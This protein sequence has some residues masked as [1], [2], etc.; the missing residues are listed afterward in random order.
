MSKY[1]SYVTPFKDTVVIDYTELFG[2]VGAA[3][4]AGVI[5]EVPN[6]NTQDFIDFIKGHRDK[7]Y[8]DGHLYVNGVRYNPESSQIDGSGVFMRCLSEPYLFSVRVATDGDTY[9]TGKITIRCATGTHTSDDTVELYV[10]DS[11]VQEIGDRS[12]DA[13][14]IRGR[15]NTFMLMRTNPKLTGNIKLVVDSGGHL[16]LDTFKVS[17][18]LN[19]RVYRKYPV[20][21]DGNYPRDVMTVFGSLPKSELFKTAADTLN[22]H[23]YYTD[24]KQQYIT[25]YEYGAET[26]TDNMYPENM[27]ILAPIHI[28]KNVP[29][30]FCVF[31]YDGTYNPDTYHSSDIDDRKLF[32]N[33][34][35]TATVIKIFDLRS[36]TAVG[37]YIHNYAAMLNQ[38]LHGSCFL[39]FIEQDNDRDSKNYRQGN[40]SWRGIDVAHGLITNKIESSYFA[41]NI[42][43]SGDAVQEK[44]NDY[45]IDG[46]ERNN[47]LYPYILNLEF[48]FNDTDSEEFSMNRYYGLYL[49]ANEYQKYSCIIS[50]TLSET[51]RMLKLDGNDEPVSD[52]ALIRRTVGSADYA[53]RIFFMTTNNDAA[54]VQSA[55]DVKTFIDDYVLDNPDV[56]IANITSVPIEWKAGDRSFITLTFR[57]PVYYGE[58]LRFVC[59]NWQSAAGDTPE[60]ICLEI[61]A[62]NDERLLSEDDYIS[63]YVLT[64]SPDLHYKT[65]DGMTGTSF[66]RISFY[67]QSTTDASVPA[68]VP[69]QMA[70][71]RAA[72]AR[73]G[74]FVK[75]TS[76][77]DDTLCVVSS[78]DDTYF[79]H[80]MPVNRYDDPAFYQ[81]YVTAADSGYAL[82]YTGPKSD[83]VTYG[84]YITGIR[85]ILGQTLIPQDMPD[86]TS[87]A[88]DG[89]FY[90][91]QGVTRAADYVEY[92]D[93]ANIITD[94]IRYFS[95][96][97][98]SDMHVL[99]P[100]TDTYSSMYMPLSM[101]G[102]ENLGWRYSSVIPFKKMTDYTWPYAVYDDMEA[103]LKFTKHPLAKGVNGRF[104]TIRR[105]KTETGY[106]TDNAI[107][108]LDVDVQTQQLVT[109]GSEMNT[110]ISPYD[111]RSVIIDF[112][113]EPFCHNS[114]IAL[115]NPEEA[116]LCVMGIMSVKDIDMRIN[117]DE[118]I[119]SSNRKTVVIPAGDIVCVGSPDENR[120][121]KDAVYRITAGS[122]QEYPMREFVMSGREIRYT[123][124]GVNVMTDAFNTGILTAASDVT[125]E[126]VEGADAILDTDVATTV[127][128]QTDDNFFKDRSSQATSYLNIPVVPQTN[129]LWESNGLYFDSNPILD[130]SVLTAGS[131]KPEGHFTEL[132]V[133]PALDEDGN[134]FLKNS[135]DSFMYGTQTG[136]ARFRDA[137]KTAS[138]R[139]ILKKMIVQ[140]GMPDTAVGYY[141]SYVQTLEFVYYGIKFGLKFNSDYYNQNIHIGEYNNFDVYFINEPSFSS[142]NEMYISVDEQIIVFVNHKFDMVTDTGKHYYPQMTAVD[143]GIVPV[144]AYSA[145]RAPYS[146]EADS[147][148]G[149]RSGS[150]NAARNAFVCSKTNDSVVSFDQTVT[151]SYF[152]QEDRAAGKYADNPYVYPSYVFFGIYDRETGRDWNT[153]DD[154]FNIA[155]PVA[156]ILRYDRRGRYVT[157]VFTATANL[158]YNTGDNNLT[159]YGSREPESYIVDT[160]DTDTG[161]GDTESLDGSKRLKRYARSISGDIVC[162]I[163]KNRTVNEFYITDNY[164]PLSITMQ[165]PARIKYNFGYF[166]PRFYDIVTFHTNDYSLGVSTGMNMLLA[167]TSVKR[168]ERLNTY[169]GNKV[170]VGTEE[171]SVAKNYYITHGRSVMASSW[172][173]GYYRKYTDNDAWSLL[174]G[175]I[176]GVEDKSFFGSRCLVLKNEYI[177][178]DD[179]SSARVN[180]QVTYTDSVHNVYSENRVQCRI[181]IN[182]TQS[183]YAKFENEPVFTANWNNSDFDKEQMSTAVGNYI[184]NSV[185]EIYNIQRRREVTVYYRRNTAGTE[186]DV[187][188]R[189]DGN[190]YDGWSILEDYDAQMTTESNEMILT[191][192]LSIGQGYTI[193]PSVKIYRN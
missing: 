93:P 59:P 67:S 43:T 104:E 132:A 1:I 98:E 167:N 112:C 63:P 125:I 30:F 123:M 76:Y 148:C 164:R 174:D 83:E 51:N 22:P 15:M 19:D 163:I 159:K 53:D 193:H 185:S 133:S 87:R 165:R 40:N 46:Y 7:G 149:F 6:S 48:M 13:N 73:F 24:F 45:I 134:A 124:D 103:I 116:A 192:T 27:R 86:R 49:T 82:H 113:T 100:D 166:M 78:A 187:D 39:Q 41:N 135:V 81:M 68:T 119:V 65:D 177:T 91:T 31:R 176:P 146:I 157:D 153:D 79:Q 77:D 143:D 178:I 105:Q 84:S 151:R 74:M 190:G 3:G 144:T 115:F 120:I 128:S 38:Y 71:I 175:Y 107:R 139:N 32:E 147:I 156:G 66:Y 54:R 61:V 16:Y 158:P 42:L 75:V 127:P 191:I 129:C 12:M 111:C 62:S 188:F 57:Q 29:D 33:L 182:I 50:D 110:L 47:L 14:V 170:F 140:N 34:L 141:N 96:T 169:T 180:P 186:M 150:G 69:E 173:M 25:C 101:F 26:N 168:L 121:R 117:L 80:I 21:G 88:Y 90:T 17:S 160:Y 130:T 171:L 37:K 142:E 89:K 28:G 114:Q 5:I 102:F 145:Y 152:V 181:T 108:L 70:R 85:R 52:D 23:K 9:C 179:F 126:L 18:V 106:L 92:E 95:R 35:R 55:D 154:L 60:N 183:I 184:Q 162:Y 138:V 99:S 94:T 161:D 131:Y 155:D 20:S 64:N 2:D 122:F 72:I 137:I 109:T 8:E 44:F 136:M 36:Y 189:A 4:N 97:S 56:N 58:H 118:D 11:D 172:D 10:S